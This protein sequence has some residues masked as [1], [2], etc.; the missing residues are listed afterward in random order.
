MPNRKQIAVILAGCGVYDGSEIHEAVF[1][2]WAIEKADAAY[3]VFAPDMDQT[4][5]INHLSG[6]K[7]P[8]KRNVLTEAARISRG[9]IA[10][11]STLDPTHFNALI[12]PGGYGVAKNLSTFNSDGAQCQVNPDVEKAVKGFHKQSKPIG[13]LCI[14][15]ALVAKILGNVKVTI[16]NDKETIASITQ[17]GGKH[18]DATHGDVVVDI[19]NKIYSTPCYM[20]EATITQVATDVENLVNQIMQSIE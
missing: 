5:I 8:G 10:P 1:T 18:I 4:Q 6:D 2:L 9:K 15:P 13:A 20:L 17:M 14:S 7:T 12:I 19:P 11:L 3:K 16:G